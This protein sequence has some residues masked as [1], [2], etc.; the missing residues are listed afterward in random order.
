[1]A[2]LFFGKHQFAVGKYVQHAAASHPE[3]YLFHS[4]LLF[5]FA[6]QAPGL[7]ANVGSKKAA[8]DLDFHG[9]TILD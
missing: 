7:M 6:L 1:V 9:C 2:G 8:L 3:L 4:G 5:Q